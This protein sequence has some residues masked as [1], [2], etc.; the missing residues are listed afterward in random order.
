MK[1]LVALGGLLA[2]AIV[3]VVLVG[4]V[5]PRRHVATRSVQINQPAVLLFAAIRDF[6]TAPSWRHD[7]RRVEMLP[8]REGKVAYRET[9]RNGVIT[10]VVVEEKTAERLV[11]EIAD[12]NLP[13]GGMWTFELSPGSA[14]GTLVRITEE[15]EVKN[16]IFRFMGRL[17]FGY[18]GTMENY[19]R[20]LGR[21]FGQEVVPQ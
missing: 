10:Y 6:A 20:D 21:K 3:V 18:A 9:S 8:P 13:F 16:P 1:W 17:V 12:K 15:G 19:L 14:G 5:L 4:S 11:V 2:A 7:V